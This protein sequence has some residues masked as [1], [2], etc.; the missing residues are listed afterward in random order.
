[1]IQAKEYINRCDQVLKFNWIELEDNRVL[2]FYG[3]M[4]GSTLL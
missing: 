4:P 2:F 3:I 1:M